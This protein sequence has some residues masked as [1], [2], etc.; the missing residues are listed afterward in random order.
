MGADARA[1]LG[2]LLGASDLKAA[3]AAEAAEAAAEQGQQAGLAPGGAAPL[4]PGDHLEMMAQAAGVPSMNEGDALAFL[5]RSWAAEM[6]Q[7]NTPRQQCLTTGGAPLG[8]TRQ[9]PAPPAEVSAL[10]SSVQSLGA[11]VRYEDDWESEEEEDEQEA[12]AEAEEAA[13]EAAEAK[14]WAAV[15]AAAAA[16][17]EAAVA[18]A[19][20]AAAAR[21]AAARAA[22]VTWKRR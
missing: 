21:A 16:E 9:A 8:H 22:A 20:K 19:A 13:V 7:D 5:A 12:A 3:E 1:A 15:E 2:S 10:R 18:V 11:S 14:E 6:R 4:A 17:V